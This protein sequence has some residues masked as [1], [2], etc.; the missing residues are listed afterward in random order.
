MPQEII[1]KGVALRRVSD[2][3]TGQRLASVKEIQTGLAAAP[4]Y[5]VGGRDVKGRPLCRP[6]SK[7]PPALR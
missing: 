1:G 2:Y 5:Y 4:N 6:M 7:A 3:V